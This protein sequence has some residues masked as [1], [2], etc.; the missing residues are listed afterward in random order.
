[1]RTHNWL[2]VF[3]E[4]ITLRT[5][6]EIVGDFCEVFHNSNNDNPWKSSDFACEA[7]KPWIYLKISHFFIFLFFIFPCFFDVFFIHS[8][9][10]SVFHFSFNFMHPF[11]Q[12]F[13]GR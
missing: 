13:L 6:I 10:F 4:K 2:L 12:I 8:S 7:K 1:M 3:S 11:F 9:I 5:N